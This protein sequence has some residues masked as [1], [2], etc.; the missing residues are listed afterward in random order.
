MASEGIG[1]R[2]EEAAGA[3]EASEG[4]RM[5]RTTLPLPSLFVG[6]LKMVLVTISSLF[7]IFIVLGGFG[8]I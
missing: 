2:G 5:T 3:D 1:R 6:V 4:I 7:G 8:E